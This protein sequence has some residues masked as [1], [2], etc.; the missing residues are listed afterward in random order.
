MTDTPFLL[1]ASE[2]LPEM[3]DIILAFRA[4]AFV[5]EGPYF[6]GYCGE[7]ISH[8]LGIEQKAGL[9]KYNG[10]YYASYKGSFIM[11]AR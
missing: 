5:E 1:L 3:D 4:S 11:I 9:F 2:R 7:H 6:E 10:V 8:H